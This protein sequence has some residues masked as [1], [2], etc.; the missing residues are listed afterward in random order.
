[1]R[2]RKGEMERRADAFLALPGGLGTFEELFE[3]WVGLTLGL[4]GKPVVVL[5][6][7][8]I[9]AGLRAQ[10]DTSVEAGFVRPAARDA[11]S[12]T[13]TV[14]EALDSVAAGWAAG[15]PPP[16]AP[17]AADLLEAEP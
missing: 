9:L 2:E 17:A 15:P 4:H 12:W 10:V 13:R 3:I 1:M 11:I 14:D 5:D 6:P 8:D 7:D 16:S